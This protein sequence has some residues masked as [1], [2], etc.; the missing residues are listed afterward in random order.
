MDSSLLI[1]LP[2][3]LR[4]IYAGPDSPRIITALAQIDLL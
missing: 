3:L 4:T 1:D 2:Y